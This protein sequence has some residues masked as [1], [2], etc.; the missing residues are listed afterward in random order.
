MRISDSK[1]KLNIE[2]TKKDLTIKNEMLI[3]RLAI[4]SAIMFSWLLIWALVLKLGS[5]VLLV[6]N[7]TNLKDMTLE[8]RLMWDLIPFNYRGTDYWKMRQMIDTLLNCF[9]FAPLGFLLCYIFEKKNILRDALICLSFSVFV[10]TMQLLTMLGN[11]STEDLITN[12]VGCFIGHIV[13]RLFFGRLSM[14]KNTIFLR[15]V[16]IIF[17]VSVA[18]SLVTTAMAVDTIIEI[19]TKTM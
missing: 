5:E 13:Y 11:P 8:E 7:Y 4:A 15:I 10:E 12:V 18:F 14:Q 3:K 17:V 2:I 16:F 6:R 9:V 1:R 19:I